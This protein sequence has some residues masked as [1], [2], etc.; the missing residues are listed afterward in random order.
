MKKHPNEFT[1]RK[2][3]QY[4]EN[5]RFEGYVTVADGGYVVFFPR[6]SIV[7]GRHV[8]D[9]AGR[10]LY[11]EEYDYWKLYWMS[12]K[13]RWHLYDRYPRLHEALDEMCS[14]HAA[15]LFAKVL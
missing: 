5:R 1:R 10:L 8:V 2:I 3:L 7:D 14:D 4:L 15:H 6:F 12:G 13:N 11:N 9:P